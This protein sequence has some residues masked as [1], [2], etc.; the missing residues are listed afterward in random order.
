MLIFRAE[1]LMEYLFTPSSYIVET[2]FFWLQFYFRN[3]DGRRKKCS[4]CSLF[5]RSFNFV[6]SFQF[7]VYVFS[8]QIEFT[9]K[10]VGHKAQHCMDSVTLQPINLKFPDWPFDEM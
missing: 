5:K 3:F 4:R 7:L 1:K 10:M 9:I 6:F 2:Q 8:L